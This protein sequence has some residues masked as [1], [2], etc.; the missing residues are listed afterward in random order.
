MLHVRYNVICEYHTSDGE[1]YGDWRSD[2]SFSIE[3]VEHV[4][5]GTKSISSSYS[6]D[7]FD[8][9]AKPGDVAYVL[10]MIYST[11]DSFGSSTG[12]G[13][14]LMVY[15]DKAI[16]Q[17]AYDLFKTAIN[18]DDNYSHTVTI[19]VQGVNGREMFKCGNPSA[20][21]FETCQDLCLEPF[22]IC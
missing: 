13:E 18:E 17:E 7:R 1:Q 2:H 15:T 10:Y 16:A 20:G 9:N 11:G 6:S 21:Y 4:A 5:E 14:V 8:I 3:R 19:P 12:N 22:V